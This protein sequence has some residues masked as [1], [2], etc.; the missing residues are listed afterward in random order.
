MSWWSLRRESLSSTGHDQLEALRGTR[1]K[2]SS[3]LARGTRLLAFRPSTQCVG[4]GNAM[5]R[6]KA[7]LWVAAKRMVPMHHRAVSFP[8][9]ILV[10][11]WTS[12]HHGDQPSQ[13]IGE[14]RHG[15]SLAPGCSD[16][17]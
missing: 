13:A 14:W 11:S 16:G 4:K 15:P 10:G 12:D 9:R 5:S 8:R 7:W 2:G 1:Q 3:D 17:F 6:R